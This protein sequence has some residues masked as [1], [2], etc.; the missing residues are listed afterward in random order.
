MVRHISTITRHL[1]N[2]YPPIF[3]IF[4]VWEAHRVTERTLQQPLECSSSVGLASIFIDEDEKKLKVHE[5]R[6]T[7]T[8]RLIHLQL[9]RSATVNKVDFILSDISQVKWC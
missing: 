2:S 7:Q 3:I 5:K 9:L 6:L 8:D 4:S 1:S